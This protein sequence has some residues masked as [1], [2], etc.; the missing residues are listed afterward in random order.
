MMPID[1]DLTYRKIL[2][3]W[4]PLALTWLMMAI[5]GPFLAAVIARMAEERVNLAAYGV[6]YS[7]ALVAE[8]P[9]IMLL[10][11]STALAR[12]KESYRRLR[13]FT[14]CLVGAVTLALLLLLL[15][16]VF[17]VVAQG[18]I[19]LSPGIAGLTHKALL[20]LIPWPAAIGLRRFYQGV[21]IAGGQTRRVAA[22]TV[23]RLL[24]MTGTAVL[25]Y[26]FALTPGACLGA[27]A[28]SVGVV[29]EV[30]A[31]RYMAG[32]AI[33][34]LFGRDLE[35]HEESMGYR[36]L[37][38]YYLPLALTPFI[39]L[40]VHPMVTFALGHSRQ[41]TASLAVM[42]VIYALTF[43]FRAIGIS[44]QEVAIAL[45]GKN[46]ENYRMVRNFAAMIAGGTALTLIGIA[47]TPLAR[48]WF[49]IVS[50][51]DLELTAF[52]VTPLR[53]V[54]VLPALTVAISLQRAIL[55]AGKAPTAPITLATA[56]EAFGVLGVMAVFIAYPALPGATAAALAY[57]VGR[58]LAIGWL[59][60]PCRRRLGRVKNVS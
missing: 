19:G 15:P 13:T 11:A 45:V 35:T 2:L 42:P 41:P 1:Q 20:L 50:G 22:A 21:M 46:F 33:A 4:L 60:R 23:V 10:S 38:R 56:L 54:A 3:F 39:A 26:R 29:T 7:F 5:E 37:W 47:F 52:A 12:D 48:V 24:G 32:P 14:I 59:G 55:V 18:L 51:L 25:V 28:L 49:H 53:L 9:V 30:L 8:A 36:E 58:V 40:G 27:L 17:R 6:A 57:I 43:V 16:P 44:Y 31:T 34:A